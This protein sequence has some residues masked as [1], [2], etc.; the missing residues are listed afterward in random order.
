MK[1]TKFEIFNF[2]GIKHLGLDLT[3]Q[4]NSNVITLVGLNESGK[5]TI[6]QAIDWFYH[7]LHY[8]DHELM[9]KDKRANFG[10]SISVKANV[11][12]NG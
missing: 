11:K 1:Y 10:D 5:T 7:P 2:K 12:L 3:K 8:N 4:N 9:P 6:L